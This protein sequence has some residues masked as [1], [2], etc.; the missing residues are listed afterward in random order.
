VMVRFSSSLTPSTRLYLNCKVAGWNN[1]CLKASS[2]AKPHEIS[3][4]FLLPIHYLNKSG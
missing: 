2:N 3:W 4:G 1:S